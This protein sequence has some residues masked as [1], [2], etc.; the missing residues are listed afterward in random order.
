M[1]PVDRLHCPKPLRPSTYAA[2]NRSW[3]GSLRL[4]DETMQRKT[5]VIVKSRDDPGRIDTRRFGVN[6]ARRVEG[7][8]GSASIAHKT[9][10]HKVGIGI[11][12]CDIPRR[13]DTFSKS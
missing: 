10:P 5:L 4:A 12:S 11:E 7:R 9:V 3:L 1:K 13:I 6:A 2:E 8:D